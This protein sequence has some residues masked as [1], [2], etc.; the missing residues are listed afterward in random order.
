MADAEIV[1]QVCCEFT[2]GFVV[3]LSF[4]PGKD[5]AGVALERQAVSKVD[6]FKPACRYISVAFQVRSV[7]G[8]HCPISTRDARRM[9]CCGKKSVAVVN[10]VD[11][12]EARLRRLRHEKLE[13]ARER[14]KK[15]EAHELP[16]GGGLAWT[17][18]E[19]RRPPNE[20]PS[21]ENTPRGNSAPAGLRRSS[22]S[23]KSS[24]KM[25]IQTVTLSNLRQHARR[26]PARQVAPQS[27][28]EAASRS[29]Q[30]AYV[31]YESS[32]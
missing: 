2:P 22:A 24:K 10:P 17:L 29:G 11:E 18:Q 23:W 30:S 5:E 27:A 25:L 28:T 1:F 14:A 4:S 16:V 6:R 13:R 21:T 8:R 15:R 12:E 31:S 19:G 26:G 32:G 3:S 9:P 20:I 7:P